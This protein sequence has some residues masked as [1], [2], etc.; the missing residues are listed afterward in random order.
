MAEVK[1]KNLWVF[2]ETDEKGNAKSVGLELLTVGRGLADKQGGALVGI[3]IGNKVDA[4]IASAAEYGAD[5]V[6][7]VDA[8]AFE[9]YSTD[10]LCQGAV[11]TGREVRPDH[12][13]DWRDQQR[14]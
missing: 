5:E 9:H 3:V 12:D 11:H 8:P 7:A 2:V 1:N 14:P 4:A 13:P 6:I 10:A